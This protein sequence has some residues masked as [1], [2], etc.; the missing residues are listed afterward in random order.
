MKTIKT[1]K[2]CLRYVKAG[3]VTVDVPSN[4]DEMNDSSKSVW[5]NEHLESLDSEV[6]Y[7]SLRDDE[8]RFCEAIE[9]VENGYT[10]V[11]PYTALWKAYRGEI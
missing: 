11:V 3:S 1:K 4:W 8:D 6:I 2:L 5:A 10:A 7:D 9:S